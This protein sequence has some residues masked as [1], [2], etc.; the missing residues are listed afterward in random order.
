MPSYDYECTND[1][2]LNQFTVWKGINEVSSITH[3]K[4][5]GIEAKRIYKPTNVNLNFSGSYNSTRK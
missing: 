2:C 4:K 3:C 1:K 5:C